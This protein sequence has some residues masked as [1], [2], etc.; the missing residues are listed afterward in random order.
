MTTPDPISELTGEIRKLLEKID[1]PNRKDWFDRISAVTPLL[2][3]VVVAGVALY[4]S[5]SAQHAEAV[6]QRDLQQA[7]LEVQK[8]QVRIEELK[9]L[10]TFAP[11]L[12]SHDSAQRA[13]AF[14]IMDAVKGGGG[15]I[16]RSSGTGDSAAPGGTSTIELSLLDSFIDQAR[17][18]R[19]SDGRRIAALRQMGVVASSSSAPAERVRAF[20]VARAIAGTPGVSDSLRRTAS[21]VAAGIR[22]TESLSV[23]S[24][25]PAPPPPPSSSSDD[26]ASA[27]VA[28]LVNEHRRGV[29]CPA[30]RWD[31]AA[32][33]TAQS[34][35]ENLSLSSPTVDPSMGEP[36]IGER[37]RRAGVTW[38]W[39]AEN[40][41]ADQP[42]SAGAV[43]AWTNRPGQRATM[44]NCRYTHLGV[45]RVGSLW[46]LV[47]YTPL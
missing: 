35:I 29:G 21:D 38:R 14:S 24:P 32:A 12:A 13:V 18:A 42:T 17:D 25:L 41:A 33:R 4:F 28:R 2:S 8:A 27:Q 20:G 19:A 40:I 15:P 36:D 22:R 9:A 46:T 16:Q 44:E 43:R 39:V 34:H 7:Q 31:A 30:L 11:L 1:T 3:S 47:L 23:V 5:Q 45:G 10:T 37:L 6:R 26:T